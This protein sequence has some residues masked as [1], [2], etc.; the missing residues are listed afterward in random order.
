MVLDIA[1]DLFRFL[2]CQYRH[3]RSENFFLHDPDIVTVLVR[4]VSEPE[5]RRGYLHPF[6]VSETTE[7]AF[8]PD[9]LH[10]TAQTVEMFPVYDFSIVGICQLVE[11]VHPEDFPFAVFQETVH[12]AFVDNDVVRSYAGLP[13]VEVFPEY[14][15]GS[16]YSDICR[17]RDYHRAFPTQFEGDRG[18]MAR[19][20]FHHQPSYGLA[21]GEKDIVEFL[22]QQVRIHIASSFHYCGFFFGEDSVDQ[23]FDCRRC[24]RGVGARLQND[25]IPGCNGT[26]QR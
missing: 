9:F 12:D 11:S 4:Y 20:L 17:R 21:T 1:D 13:A 26:D 2:V 7:Y 8:P 14:C 18:E 5:N 23:F 16:G 22:F 25:R 6:F 15:P 10:H 24:G 19:C 3:Q